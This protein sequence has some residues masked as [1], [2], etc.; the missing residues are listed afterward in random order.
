MGAQ[1]VNRE[2][3]IGTGVATVLLLA[4]PFVGGA[5]PSLL[6]PAHAAEESV[7][8][9]P[10]ASV[11]TRV[12]ASST[13]GVRVSTGSTGL[14]STGAVTVDTEHLAQKP[15]PVPIPVSP[16][17]K[18]S[19]TGARQATLA[20][21]GLSCP[22]NVGGSVGSAP[23]IT[24]AGGVAGTTSADLASFALAYN[25]IRT[26]NCLPAV[27]LANFRYDACMEQR[28]FWM[29]EDPSTDPSSAWGHIGSVRSDG[30][31][32]VG[33]DGNLAGGTNNSGATVAN[34][35]WVSIPH[36]TSLYKPTQTGS[37]AGVCI[38]FAMTHGGVPDE[39]YAFARAAARWGG[40]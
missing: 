38:Y 21:Q 35:W 2:M 25:S 15:V 11:V 4:L 23:G 40:C 36:R 8:A 28:L 39:P 17:A 30:V 37:T 16:A 13:G 19:G 34:K 32:S 6:A 14:V 22:A 3:V 27:P 9:P 29:A 31:P 18:A 24:S 1:S 12:S 10:A 26:A 5:G 20:A 7:S 33:C